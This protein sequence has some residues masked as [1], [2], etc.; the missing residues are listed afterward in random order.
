MPDEATRMRNLTAS[1]QA[2]SRKVDELHVS[3][4][5]M[6]DSNRRWRRV[7]VV[8][9]AVFVLLLGGQTRVIWAQHTED[10][11]RARFGTEF[12]AG[13]AARNNAAAEARRTER[14]WLGAYTEFLHS[15]QDRTISQA[16]RDAA[17]QRIFVAIAAKTAALERQDQANAA[18]PV[19]LDSDC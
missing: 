15:I 9:L 14:E 16:D 3:V 5:N 13:L 1:V 10:D 19:V 11:C 7:A 17:Y 2:F 8:V 4:D 18:N 6:V 12:R